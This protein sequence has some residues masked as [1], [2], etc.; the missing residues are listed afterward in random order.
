[1]DA[2]HGS[3]HVGLAGRG[4][5]DTNLQV[6]SFVQQPCSNPGEF[7]ELPGKTSRHEYGYLREFC[8]L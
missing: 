5:V 6:I 7:P 8:N 2:A 4:P 3:R 1:M